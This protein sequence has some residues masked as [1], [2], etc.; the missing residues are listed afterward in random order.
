LLCELPVA[1]AAHRAACNGLRDDGAEAAAGPAEFP[2][3]REGAAYHKVKDIALD[4]LMAEIEAQSAAWPGDKAAH[5]A[6]T[7]LA[8]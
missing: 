6:P 7:G 4:A 2:P 3:G 8:Y 1:T 5:D